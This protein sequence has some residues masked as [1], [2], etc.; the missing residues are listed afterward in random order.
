VTAV[1]AVSRRP[2]GWR[3]HHRAIVGDERHWTHGGFIEYGR[4]ERPAENGAG[5]EIEP[6]GAKVGVPGLERRVAVDD[7]L[8]VVA[9]VRQERLADPQHHFLRLLLQR[10]A[11]LYAG[12]HEEALAVADR[13]REFLEPGRGARREFLRMVDAIA[14]ERRV[15]AV[16][17]PQP[18]IP[19]LG[20]VDQQLLVVAAQAND[21]FRR[22]PIAFPSAG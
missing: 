16:V 7:E 12:V 2:D 18:L 14:I 8:A 15:A 21:P 19:F 20:G 22:A 3:P 6:V 5:V 9:C 10:Y 11:G 17:E 13:E 4:R 1:Q